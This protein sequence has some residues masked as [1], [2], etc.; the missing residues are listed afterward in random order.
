MQADPTSPAVEGRASTASPD[1]LSLVQ[2]TV[3]R[4]LGQSSPQ[5]RP[6][7]DDQPL[8]EAGLDSLGAVELR[9]E[10]EAVFNL[11]MPATLT[12]DYP[13]I[14]ALAAYISSCTREAQPGAYESGC[15]ALGS[16]LRMCPACAR[17]HMAA[18]GACLTSVHSAV[19]CCANL[20]CS[21]LLPAVY[22]AG[23]CCLA[24]SKLHQQGTAA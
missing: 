2:S 23:G 8:M 3:H 18:L 21:N 1:V 22:Q 20:P 11:V 14:A 4:V 5:G 12:F 9:T 16:Q 6:I 24:P 19:P 10:L 17:T 15:T 13:T 7:D